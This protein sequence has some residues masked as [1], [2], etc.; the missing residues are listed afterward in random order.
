M[1]SDLTYALFIARFPG[2]TDAD[3]SR[4]TEIQYALDD[5]ELSVHRAT[6]GD[7][8]DLA[9]MLLAAHDLTE[10]G[11]TDQHGGGGAGAVTART[12]GPGVVG[13]GDP[14][15][16]KSSDEYRTTPYGVRYLRLRRQ[17]VIT[18]LGSS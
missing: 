17:L 12:V 9:V 5:A 1:A 8:A 6:W 2:F 7:T 4:Q 11:R 15:Q 3:S 10:K 16:G 13:Y 18:P 14:K